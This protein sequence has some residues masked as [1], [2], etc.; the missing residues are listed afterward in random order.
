M[1]MWGL[2]G[3]MGTLLEG[4]TGILRVTIKYKNIKRGAGEKVFLYHWK[5]MI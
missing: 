3:G 2:V 4:G 1:G 5:R